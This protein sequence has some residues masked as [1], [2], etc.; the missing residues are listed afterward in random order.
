[1]HDEC[2][3]IDRNLRRSFGNLKNDVLEISK[4]LSEQQSNLLQLLENEKYLLTRIKALEQKKT[5]KVMEKKIVLQTNKTAPKTKEYLG[6][7]TSKKVHDPVCP[8]A[9]NIKPKNKI[10]FKTKVKAFN[11]GYRPCD[12]LK[13]V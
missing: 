13:K 9:K 2:V 3:K 5:E 6:A 12:C 8:F 4:K 1:M 10:T 7:K 11:L